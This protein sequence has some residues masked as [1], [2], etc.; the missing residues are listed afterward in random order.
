MHFMLDLLAAFARVEAQPWV[1]FMNTLVLLSRYLHIV[2][3]TLLVGGTLFYEMVVPVAIAD[4]KPEQQLAIFARA[5]WVFRRIVWFAS[6]LI[7]VT[8]IAQTGRHW[9]AYAHPERA[10]EDYVRAA[11]IQAG[12]TLPADRSIPI[13]EVSPAMQPGWWWVAHS[14]TAAMSILIALFLTIGRTPP[15]YPIYWMRLNLV[16][17]MIVIFL[18]SATRHVRIASTEPDPSPRAISSRTG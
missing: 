17:L 11:M 16:I 3:T 12:T 13:P 2:C 14:S 15:T 7:I 9:R 10:A 5:R 18:A 6:I 8:G 1:V 4:L